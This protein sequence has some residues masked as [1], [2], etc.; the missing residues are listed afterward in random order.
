MTKTQLSKKALFIL[1]SNIPN[2]SQP[3]RIRNKSSKC[4]ISTSAHVHT[5]RFTGKGTNKPLLEEIIEL[6]K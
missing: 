4:M 5:L 3:S 1:A 6:S 2:A